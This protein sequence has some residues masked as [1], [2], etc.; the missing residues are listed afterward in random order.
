MIFLTPTDTFCI[1]FCSAID[2]IE[3]DVT[4]QIS[5]LQHDVCARLRVCTCAGEIKPGMLHA[6]LVFAFGRTYCLPYKMATLKATKELFNTVYTREIIHCVWEYICT[7]RRAIVEV[8]SSPLRAETI[9]PLSMFHPLH[10]HRDS[11]DPVKKKH[12]QINGYLNIC[13]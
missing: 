13:Q 2:R 7:L 10:P 6:S 5:A 4:D 11:Q 3:Y 9:I 8:L 1:A 12:A